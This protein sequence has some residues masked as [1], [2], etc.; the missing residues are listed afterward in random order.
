MY[1]YYVFK[2]YNNKVILSSVSEYTA[3]SVS[4]VHTPQRLT[5][6]LEPA[7]PPVHGGIPHSIYFLWLR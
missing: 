7:D 1:V 4:R 3:I 6:P 2:L 5:V